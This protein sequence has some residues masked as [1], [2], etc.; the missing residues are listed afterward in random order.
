M[1]SA[2]YWVEKLGLVAHPE[3]GYFKETYRSAETF[4]S[5]H[6][7]IDFPKGRNFSTSISFLLTGNNFSAFHKIKSDEIW[8]FYDGEPIEI[9][10]FENEL[11]RILLGSNPENDEVFQ[12]VV[13]AGCW[14]ASR[15]LSPSGF[16][17]VGCTVSPGFDFQDFEMA[18]RNALILEY[19]SYSDIIIALT[20]S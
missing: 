1:H 14:F 2:Q 15:L 16:G 9:F 11:K 13:P 7:G 5:D 17:L 6:S 3:G 19:P 10:Y 12:A 4:D 18:E 8:H 20:R